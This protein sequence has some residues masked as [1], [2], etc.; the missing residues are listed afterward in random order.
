[1]QNKSFKIVISFLAVYLIWGSTYM[2]IRV[3][4]DS[5]PP[6]ISMG[7]RFSLAASLIYL[8]L[9]FKGET[10]INKKELLNS[11]IIGVLLFSGGVGMVAWAEKYVPS[12]IASV[13]VALLPLWF[14][15][16]DM[17]LNKGRKPKTIVWIGI[18]IGFSGIL[19][20]V[21]FKDLTSLRSIPYL[22]FIMILISSIL[23]SFAAVLS[24]K[25]EKPKNSLLNLTV[26]MF[27]GGL[28]NMI[29]GSFTGE[30]SNFEFEVFNYESIFALTYL[31]LFGSILVL[32]AFN[33]LIENVS[34]GMVA[35]YSYVNPI[36]ALFLGW[37]I[38]NEEIN[39]QII[40]A[41]CLIL[42][43]V[44]FIKLGDKPKLSPV[45]RKVK[46]RG[47]G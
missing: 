27:A 41:S 37:L 26:Q 28:G 42:I 29:I 9:L 23:W 35:T 20:L 12:G 40:A 16:F 18:M 38:L 44:A 47:G 43:G 17:L 39:Y 31:I 6:F 19:L 22:P 30:L 33:Y 46:N 25:L 5:A 21:G 13:M 7:I 11:S 14:L 15:L 4:V 36:V 45:K 2:A 3:I 32:S 10:K 24:P 8:F 1:M 34:P